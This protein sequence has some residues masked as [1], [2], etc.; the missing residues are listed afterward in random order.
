MTYTCDSHDGEYL[1]LKCY[2]RYNERFLKRRDRVI[3][4][5][6]K[7]PFENYITELSGNMVKFKDVFNEL[8][9]YLSDDHVHSY[10][11]NNY[12]CCRYMSYL[13]HKEV[14]KL[15]N[16]ICDEKIFKKFQDFAKMLT[17]SIKTS[18]CKEN[19]N[20]LTTDV[21]DNMR[22]LYELYDYYNGIKWLRVNDD[23]QKNMIC[24][25]L[26]L[27][28]KSFNEIK[29]D[30]S[31]NDAFY[32]KLEHL[33]ELMKSE[34][35]WTTDKTCPINL[36]HI[37]LKKNDPP[38]ETVASDQ[39]PPQLALTHS[40]TSEVAEGP[41]TDLERQDTPI[42]G[43]HLGL[44]EASRSHTASTSSVESEL[45]GTLE[46]ENALRPEEEFK[47]HLSTELDSGRKNIEMLQRSHER[48]LVGTY[49]HQPFYTHS[50]PEYRYRGARDEETL[51]GNL[52]IPPSDQE[53]ASSSVMSTIT[54]ALKDVD[55]VP[56]V[57]VSEEE[58]GAYVEFLVV[59][60][61]NS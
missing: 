19:F 56:V 23:Y 13:I 29:V 30:L 7:K 14:I 4:S 8:A 55:P 20:Y 3:K 38:S 43:V 40:L 61:D 27:F 57:G 22:V 9:L 54:S 34:R 47:S 36:N 32:R 39:N 35:T 10:E 15:N 53:R 60:T 51:I 28:V 21:I 46:L 59:S 31:K 6:Y 18:T 11:C 24:D 49:T 25:T 1:D 12:I 26:A 41:K 2:N 50:S 44:D 45:R 16:T 5:E 58:E 17:Q 48:E 33:K 37:T 52:Q 42:S